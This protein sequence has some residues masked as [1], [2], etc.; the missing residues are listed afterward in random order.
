MRLVHVLALLASSACALP[1]ARP[2][3]PDGSPVVAG[4]EEGVLVMAHGGSAEWNQ[5][6]AAAVAPL[7]ARRPTALALGMADPVTLQ[8]ALD[9]LA[10]MGVRRV[11]V[12]RLFLSGSSFLHQTEYLFGL[13]A[14][15]PPDPML[16]HDPGHGGHG[17]G[18]LRPLRHDAEIILGRQGLGE[19]EIA[20]RILRER[21]DDDAPA[22]VRVLLLA[23]GMGEESENDAVLRDMSAV[24]D[25]FRLAGVAE[26]EVATLREDWPEE[27]ALAETRIRTW[28]SEGRPGATVVVPFR[29]FGFGPYA[30]VLDGLSYSETE[31]L[32]PHRLV[33][34]WVED[35]A[36]ALLCRGTTG[37][38]AAVDHR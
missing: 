2:P 15:P 24:A 37:C 7:R 10:G 25:A 11:A 5:A 6:V 13:R 26:V 3:A 28:V 21:I 23:H 35:Q 4:P 9:T 17:D 32:L 14:D 20:A 1:S 33:G 8:A 22:D 36:S 31:G 12:V 27:R 18:G 38:G 16:G 29:L 30:Q 34:T 19:S